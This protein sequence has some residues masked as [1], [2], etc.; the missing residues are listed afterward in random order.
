MFWSTEVFTAVVT[1]SV[2]LTPLPE[3]AVGMIGKYGTWQ[4]T[5]AQAVYRGYDPLPYACGGALMSPTDLGKIF[6]VRRVPGDARY[7]SLQITTDWFGPCL[8]DDTSARKDFIDNVFRQRKVAEMD[9]RVADALGGWINDA[10]FWGEVYV[11]ICPPDE[12]ET[13]PILYFYGENP[14]D[15][16]IDWADPLATIGYRS[17]LYP[18]PEQQFPVPCAKMQETRRSLFDYVAKVQTESK[19]FL[20]PVK[21]YDSVRPPAKH[22]VN[23]MKAI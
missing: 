10:W 19:C 7:D 15:S 9:D 5:N 4:D 20:P 22:K 17:S 3:H 13:P 6:W 18:F 1:L 12:D 23:Q 14:V 11:G 2:W 16:M 8:A 21:I